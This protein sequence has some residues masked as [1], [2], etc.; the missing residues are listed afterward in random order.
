MIPPLA[1]RVY[2]E[3]DNPQMLLLRQTLNCCRES[4]LREGFNGII[5]RA[6]M[7]DDRAFR[8]SRGLGFQPMQK[9]V[10]TRRPLLPAARGT[11]ADRYA[12][13]MELVRDSR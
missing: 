7:F 3:P 2:R 8:R 11:Q 1:E 5:G 4:W 12:R 6:V 9:N 10:R 13:L